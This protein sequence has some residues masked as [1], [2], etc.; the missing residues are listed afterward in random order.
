[1]KLDHH[2]DS[3]LLLVSQKVN[4]RHF[5]GGEIGMGNGNGAQG[6]VIQNVSK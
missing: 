3:E 2:H 5:L 1:M 4:F 6:N